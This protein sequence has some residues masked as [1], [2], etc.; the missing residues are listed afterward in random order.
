MDCFADKLIGEG[1]YKGGDKKRPLPGLLFLVPEKLLETMYDIKCF[2]SSERKEFF[3]YAM[4][5]PEEVEELIKE[6]GKK[7]E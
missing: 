1:N 4:N 5:N 2:D 7:E 3:K 6:F